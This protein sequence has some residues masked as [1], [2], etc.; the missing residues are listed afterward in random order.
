MLQLL[1]VVMGIEQGRAV[2]VGPLGGHRTNPYRQNEGIVSMNQEITALSPRRRALQVLISIGLGLAGLALVLIAFIA[3]QDHQDIRPVIIVTYCAFFAAGACSPQRDSAFNRIGAILVPLG[4]ILSGLALRVSDVAFTDGFYAALI[5]A[6]AIA[7]A[8]MGVTAR[9]LVLRRRFGLAGAVSCSSLAV[10]I[11]GALWVVPQVLDERAYTDVDRPIAPFSVRTLNGELVRSD[12]W[13]GRVVVISYWATWCTPCLS[14]IPEIAALQRK[15]KDDPRVAVV[16]LNAGY[17]GD[18]AQKAG[19]FLLRRRFDIATEIDDIK[20][21]GRVKGEGAIHMGLKVVP[22]LFILNKDQK[23]VAVHIGF[24]SSEH[25][26]TTLA[27]RINS[28]VDSTP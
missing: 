6:T 11:A 5:A 7:A 23:L 26:A 14:E 4:G 12:T 3:M 27:N 22:T 21:D 28:L 16:A 15:Y 13:R 19:D 9:S 24:D 18:N 2:P 25:L 17:G 1:G 20:T 10:T 8:L